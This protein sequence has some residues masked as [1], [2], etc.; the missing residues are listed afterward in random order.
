M[1]LGHVNLLSSGDLRRNGWIATVIYRLTSLEVGISWE[2]KLLPTSLEVEHN[3]T[4][5]SSK[6]I[7]LDGHF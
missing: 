4:R 5:A 6:E 3:E 7:S 2:D 1:I